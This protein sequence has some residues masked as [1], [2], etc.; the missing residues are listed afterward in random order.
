MF[1]FQASW[2]CDYHDLKS[3]SSQHL[4]KAENNFHTRFYTDTLSFGN[5]KILGVL[6]GSEYSDLK[7]VQD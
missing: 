3:V 1:S 2:C 4:C 5:V 6:P 7:V